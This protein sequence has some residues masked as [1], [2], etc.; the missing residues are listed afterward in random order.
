MGDG[1]TPELKY[2]T[3]REMAMSL[4]LS[5][6]AIRNRIKR[7]G[8]PMTR[9]AGAILVSLPDAISHL[10]YPPDQLCPSGEKGGSDGGLTT[11]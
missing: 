3:V 11:K 5:T 4:G 10:G 9:I 7:S 8:C 2:L 6:Q 1:F